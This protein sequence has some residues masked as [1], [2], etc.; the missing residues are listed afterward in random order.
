MVMQ[1]YF[2][3]FKSLAINEQFTYNG[4]L[5]YKSST[6]T[7]RLVENDRVFYFTLKTIVE[8]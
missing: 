3:T 2:L 6:R 4:T 1:A 5:Y 8:I 7:A